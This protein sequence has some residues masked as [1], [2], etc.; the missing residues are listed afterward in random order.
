MDMLM[1]QFCDN[2]IAKLTPAE[3]DLYAELLDEN[4]ADIYHWIISPT[5]CPH[6]KYEY[7][8]E[9]MRSYTPYVKRQ[10]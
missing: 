3:L 5:T 6:T 2:Y 4:D 7:I 8:L 9:K 1:G 10:K